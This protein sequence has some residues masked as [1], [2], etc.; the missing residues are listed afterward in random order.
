MREGRKPF[1][2][3]EL[4]NVGKGVKRKVFKGRQ[5]S[6]NGADREEYDEHSDTAKG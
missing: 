1:K 6:E 2:L 5:F 4:C 3:A